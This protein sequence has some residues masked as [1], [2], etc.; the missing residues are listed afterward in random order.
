MG[1]FFGFVLILFLSA[2]YSSRHYKAPFSAHN[3]YVHDQVVNRQRKGQKKGKFQTPCLLDAFCF[4]QAVPFSFFCIFFFF[5]YMF[6]SCV[7]KDA[8]IIPDF[9]KEYPNCYDSCDGW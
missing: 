7:L 5:S 8:S 1:S 4:T 6:S 9:G 3:G 2:S